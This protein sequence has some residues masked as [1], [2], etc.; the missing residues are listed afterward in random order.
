MDKH[1]LIQAVGEYV[2]SAAEN[3]VCAE[4]AHAGKAS[5]VKMYER[6]IFAFGAADDAYF[7]LL[8]KD[9][10]IGEHFM[11]PADWLP[12]ARTV[13]AFFMPLSETVCSTNREEQVWPSAEWL[14]A[15]LEGQQ[16]I[17]AVCRYVQSVLE[18]SGYPSLVPGLDPRFWSNTDKPDKPGHFTSNWSER[19]VAYICGLGTFGLSKGLITPKGT[20]GRLGSVITTMYLQPDNR[21]YDIFDQYCT[22]CG[23][24]VQRC[25]VKA[26][27]KEEGKDH[28]KCSRFI[29]RTAEKFNPRYGCGKCQVGV[30]CEFELPEADAVDGA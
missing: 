14:H 30:P 12:G 10:V 18:Q 22:R 3:Y 25:P 5:M 27:S 2:D 15:R 26:I 24:C 23:K 9:S 13:I 4:T 29:D 6:P 21:D 8:K 17:N 19:H 1:D 11:L 28:H 7:K 16:F 20:A